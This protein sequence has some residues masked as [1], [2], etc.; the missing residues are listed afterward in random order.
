[1][2]CIVQDKFA[3]IN[4]LI[5]IVTA[6]IMV[7]SAIIRRRRIYEM[8]RRQIIGNQSFTVREADF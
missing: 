8:P 7:I 6:L 3:L 2:E 1:M 5:I 4:A